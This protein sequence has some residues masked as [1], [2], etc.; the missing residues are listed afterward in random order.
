MINS[1]TSNTQIAQAQ[2]TQQHRQQQNVQT[3]K[4]NQEEPQD[5]VVLS[6]QASGAGDVDN[7][8]NK[9]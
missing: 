2:Q 6:K 1:V 3:Q 5:T 9:H 8:S 4:R 7:G